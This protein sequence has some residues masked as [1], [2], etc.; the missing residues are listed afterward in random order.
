LRRSK[1]VLHFFSR[2]PPSLQKRGKRTYVTNASQCSNR[3]Y[4]SM[5]ELSVG[6]SPRTVVCLGAHCDD[7]EIGCG[8]T[9]LRMCEQDPR[10]RVYWVVLSSSKVREEEARRSAERFLR[11]AAEKHIVIK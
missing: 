11:N 9:V 10:V 2:T 6:K 5:I 3:R 1:Q 7:I 8:G 4:R